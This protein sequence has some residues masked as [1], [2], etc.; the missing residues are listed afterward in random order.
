MNKASHDAIQPPKKV[1][2]FTDVLN[3]SFEP[4]PPGAEEKEEHMQIS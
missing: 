1:Y 4:P 2:Y 3:F